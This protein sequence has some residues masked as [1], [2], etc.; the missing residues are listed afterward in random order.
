MIPAHA[1]RERIPSLVGD[2]ILAQ[3]SEAATV[4]VR[5]GTPAELWRE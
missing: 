3:D 2:W 5:E 4:L 1:V